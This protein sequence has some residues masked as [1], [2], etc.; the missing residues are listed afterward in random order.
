[1]STIQNYPPSGG[2]GA[3]GAVQISDTSSNPLNSNGAGALKVDGSAVTQ[4]VSAAALPLP[5]GAATAAK[6]PALGTAGTPSADVISVQGV[7]G[8]TALKVDGSAT[9]QPVSGTVTANQGSAAALASAWPVKVT[10]GT[11][12]MPTG[13]VAARAQF[14][15]L[16][17]G[18]N[19]ATVKAASTA[20]VATDTAIVVAVSPNNAVASTQSGTWN[21]G[22]NA[23]SNIIGKVSI[24]Q[25][26]PG[27]TNGV[28]VNAALP[29]GTNTIGSVKV[30]DGTSTVTIKAAS[31]APVATDTAAV[32]AISPNTPAIATK[33]AVSV[34]GSGSAASA[35]VGTTASTLTAPA[36]CVG[37]ILQCLDTSTAN[38]RWAI[39]RTASATLGQQLQPGRDTGFI[40]CGA[41][42]SV[43]A[44]SGTQNLDIQWVS[45]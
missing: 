14:K 35:T 24:D 21:V 33:A 3:G 38:I 20:A 9:T 8:M 6:Q 39:G 45:Q 37:F 36:N 27:T 43:C 18:T 4:P 42:V 34:N 13:D 16:T 22:I 30:T 5:A 44:E 7:T 17:D 31:T 32:V 19:T 11:N 25:T 1:M 28:Q 12:T 40:P 41:N 23:G 15:K 2:G 26:T 10:D 29:T